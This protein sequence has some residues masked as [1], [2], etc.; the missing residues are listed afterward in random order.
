VLLGGETRVL[1]TG[2]SRGIGRAVAED[3]L[4]RGCTVGLVARSAEALQDLGAG[5]IALPADV[6]DRAQVETALARFTEEAGGLEV[7]VANA[8][9][10][11]YGPFRDAPIE[12]AEEMTRVNW[13]GTLYAVHA[14]LPHML[15]RASGHIAIVSSVAGH[16]TF[17][18]AA[19]YGA[20]KMAQRG[21]AEALRHELSGTGVEVTG[22]YPGSVDTH[23]H[24]HARAHGRLPDWRRNEGISA[25]EVAKAIADGIEGRRPAVY[26]PR[27]TRLLGIVH[28]ISPALAD[29]MLRA[30][31]GGTAAPAGRSR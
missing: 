21:F 4:A 1:V 25:A 15:D 28:G 13:L 10:A 31:L 30:I 20:T 9:V 2:A 26:V 29:R 7:L 3:L 23:L 8:G 18:W 14:A 16:R 5:A 19:V 12:E 24:D 11:Y 27:A 17:P 22:V 6:G